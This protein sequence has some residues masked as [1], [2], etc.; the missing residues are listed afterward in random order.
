MEYGTWLAR[1]DYEKVW[2][3]LGIAQI[4]NIQNLKLL[5]LLDIGIQYEH[6]GKTSSK[7]EIFKTKRSL[8]RICQNT[9][10]ATFSELVGKSY[11][12]QNY[13]LKS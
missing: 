8:H 6:V 3:Q 7:L 5:I 4:R 1:Y 10:V 12:D 13:M 11:Y 2:I 9:V